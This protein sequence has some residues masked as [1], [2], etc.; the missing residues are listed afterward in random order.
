MTAPNI[1]NLT[2]YADSNYVVVAVEFSSS[3]R[4]LL[5]NQSVVAV[6]E[7][8]RELAI[9]VIPGELIHSFSL[10]YAF[11]GKTA[12]NVLLSMI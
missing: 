5:S 7:L 8:R 3:R 1:A 6:S 9:N 11:V 2:V 12:S 10:A 4:R